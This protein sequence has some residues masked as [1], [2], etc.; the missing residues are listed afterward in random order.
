MQNIAKHCKT[1]QNIIC[2]Y[3]CIVWPSPVAQSRLQGGHSGFAKLGT[4][5]S[6]QHYAA[7]AATTEAAAYEAVEAVEAEVEAKTGEVC[8]S[9]RT[10]VWLGP[11]Q[12]Y[13][14]LLA[15]LGVPWRLFVFHF[16]TRLLSPHSTQGAGL[17]AACKVLGTI[18]KQCNEYGM[19][20]NDNNVTILANVLIQ[21]RTSWTKKCRLGIL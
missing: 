13:P 6:G 14:R 18:T 20:K 12:V 7:L 9:H 17:S 5:P 15:S 3:L 21:V 11:T 2:V 1:L 16:L 8:A 10:A 19:L 4:R